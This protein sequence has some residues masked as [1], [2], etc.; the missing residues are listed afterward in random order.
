VD[1]GDRGRRRD[2]GELRLRLYRRDPPA[3]AV[4]AYLAALAQVPVLLQARLS[5]TP[6]PRRARRPVPVRKLLGA[7]AAVA[8][9]VAFAALLPIGFRQLATQT[10][11]TGARPPAPQR[12]P[13]PPATG[14]ALGTMA[15][16]PAATARFA[17]AGHVVTVSVLCEG[18]G[19]MTLRIGGE[20]PTELTCDTATPAFAMLESVAALDRFTLEVVPERT[21]RWSLAVGALRPPTPTPDATRAGPTKGA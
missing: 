6:R 9:S 14:T 16:G 2:L 18:S 13:L 5:L 8:A 1:E 10:A 20:Q 11:I 12:V 3:D 21:V 17:A 19:T 7:A 15:G 4:E